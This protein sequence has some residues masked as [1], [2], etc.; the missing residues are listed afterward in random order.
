[1]SY[2]FFEAS[3]RVVIGFILLLSE[4]T[5]SAEVHL[6]RISESK[7]ESVSDVGGVQASLT[8][9]LFLFKEYLAL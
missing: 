9:V 6:H 7:S 5:T 3:D 1:M 4:L 8:H 2:F